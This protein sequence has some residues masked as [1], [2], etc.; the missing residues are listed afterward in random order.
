ML[1]FMS[2]NGDDTNNMNRLELSPTVYGI[3]TEYTGYISMPD[4]NSFELVG[5]C[6][7]K[8]DGWIPAVP[9]DGTAKNLTDYDINEAVDMTGVKHFG[10]FLANG[11]R[12]YVDVSG[13]EYATAE[14][15]SAE[16]AVHRSF[17]GDQFVLSVLTN[18]LKNDVIGSF[19]LNRRCA[20]HIGTTRG[21][22]LNVP[23]LSERRFDHPD[24]INAFAA[25][26][27][28]K[29]ALFGAGGLMLD[30]HGETAFYHSPRLAMTSELC[31]NESVNSKPLYRNF[32]KQDTGMSRLETVAGDALN[33]AWP[34]RASLVM[35]DAVA[36]LVELG[37]ER[38]VPMLVDPVAAAEAVGL[39]G[40]QAAVEVVHYDG[41]GEITTYSALQLLRLIAETVLIVDQKEGHCNQETKQVLAE[42]IETADMMEQDP[43][44]VAGRVESIARLLLFEK[45]MSLKGYSI[46]S[47]ELCRTDYYWDKIGGGLAETIRQK[48]KAGWLGFKNDHS[49]LARKKR[50]T[51]APRDTRARI[52][53]ELIIKGGFDSLHWPFVEVNG[54]DIALHPLQTTLEL[55][56]IDVVPDSATPKYQL[57]TD[58]YPF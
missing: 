43:L 44:S 51:T 45:K 12:F 22:H 31:A 15:T 2:I 10:D 37:Y 34:M 25:L 24:A 17:D 1:A 33:F 49:P 40:Y 23:I 58:L 50:L 5:A 7:D 38:K 39:H 36:K 48:N 56:T 46:D 32:F 55:P 16:E 14:T 47:E 54:L 26:N 35:T 3:E 8:N 42:V 30:I 9:R 19:Q 53:G 28:A 41:N 21:I 29:G 57:S 27:V 20:D 4:N 13:F 18:L 6:H 52:R 11:G